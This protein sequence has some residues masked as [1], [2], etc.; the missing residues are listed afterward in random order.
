[1]SNLN[2]V[3]LCKI[4]RQI[5]DYKKVQYFDRLQLLLLLLLLLLSVQPPR[6]S[7]RQGFRDLTSLPG[8]LNFGFDSFRFA[9]RVC[10]S[11]V[12]SPLPPAP[13]KKALVASFNN[14]RYIMIQLEARIW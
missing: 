3:W 9:G 2:G 1:M 8:E 13:R 10:V 12:S 7:D 5:T 4:T 6:L 14:I 11:S